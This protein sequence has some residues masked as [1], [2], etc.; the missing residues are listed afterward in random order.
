MVRVHTRSTGWELALRAWL[1]AAATVACGGKALD[2]GS[3]EP[4]AGGGSGGAAAG[5]STV[6]GGQA[7]AAGVG[8]GGASELPPLS[9]EELAALQWPAEEP[10]TAATGAKVGRWKGHWPDPRGAL[11][12][13]I[14]LEL[15]G[16]TPA[17][18]PC[19]SVTIGDGPALPPATDPDVLYPPESGS[20]GR[21]DYVGF[22]PAP[23]L[24]D[25]WLGYEHRMLQVQASATRL[26]FT[27][28]YSELMRPWCQLQ[29]A[30]AGSYSC[31]PTIT[32]VTSLDS[33]GKQCLATGPDTPDITVPCFKVQYCST[34]V[35]FC[36]D[37][38]CDASLQGRQA[39]FELHWDGAALEGSLDQ[40]GLLFLDPVP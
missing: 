34:Y 14:V 29:S 33:E 1:L 20:G 26:A 36:H 39:Q 21:S 18:V 8:S 10:C 12:V 31:L 37:G 27:I 3:D 11:D 30:V 7:T 19:G 23:A 5:G 13:D 16:V 4:K 6:T 38:Q 15:K 35:C 24:Q 2:V 22:G 17:G 28:L 25:P 40:K 9:A 32:G